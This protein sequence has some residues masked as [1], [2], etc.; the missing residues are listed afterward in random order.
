MI[1]Q[2][3][4]LIDSPTVTGESSLLMDLPITVAGQGNIDLNHSP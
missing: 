1:L 3:F 4:D 2:K